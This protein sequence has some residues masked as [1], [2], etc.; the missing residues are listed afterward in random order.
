MLK[1]RLLTAAV[2]IPLL[3]AAMFLLPGFWWQVV[4]LAPLLFAAR[5]WSRLA[6]FG[7]IHETMFLLALAA[8][9]GMLWNV[10]GE[11]VSQ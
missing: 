6:A 10:A 7:R 8:G 4:L 2:L 11:L 9:I 1:Q 5:E 3:L